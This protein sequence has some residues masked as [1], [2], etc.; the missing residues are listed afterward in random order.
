[1]KHHFLFLFHLQTVGAFLTFS[2]KQHARKY[3]N[4]QGLMSTTDDA[5]STVE[6]ANLVEGKDVLKKVIIQ[7]G[8]EGSIPAKGSEVEISYVGT[9]GG[10]QE[11]WSVD[12]VIECWLQHQQGLNDIL[13]EPFREK[14]I[15]GKMIMDS[16]VFTEEYVTNELGVANKMQCKKTIMAAKRLWK[17]KD[18]FP[19][20]SQFDS[21]LERGK[22]FSF[23]LGSGKVIKAMDMAV[24]TMNIGEKAQII[25]RSDYGYGAEGYR[26]VKGDVVV[27]PFRTLCFEIEL[28]SSS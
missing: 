15:D 28:L 4:I 17:Q 20:D 21:S 2:H 18:E 8:T 1:M 14:N 10:F 26:T 23:K 25:C 5:S 24:A 13:E 11:E 7:Q 9:L 16:N 6:W 22:S 27:P 12:D 3:T 19:K